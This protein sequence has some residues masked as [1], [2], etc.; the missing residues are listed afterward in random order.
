ME[1]TENTGKER[2]SMDK[3]EYEAAD[4]ERAWV[5]AKDKENSEIARLAEKARDKA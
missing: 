1:K 2:K 4:R 5:K 3:A